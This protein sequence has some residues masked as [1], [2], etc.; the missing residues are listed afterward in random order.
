[1]AK[2]Y[3]IKL[4]PITKTRKI[5]ESLCETCGK[6][7]I[8]KD[9]PLRNLEKTILTQL[10]NLSSTE[11]AVI[12]ETR[13]RYDCIQQIENVADDQN[14]LKFTEKDLEYLVEGFKQTAGFYPNGFVKRPQSWMK[15]CYDLFLQIDKP[16][17]EE[18]NKETEKEK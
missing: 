16:V 7:V 18:E 5:A 10:F 17:P 8:E 4:S 2:N 12:S 14:I 11:K 1:M 3:I 6:A 9:E 13:L 15:E